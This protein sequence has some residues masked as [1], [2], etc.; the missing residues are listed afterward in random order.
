MGLLVSRLFLHARLLPASR[1]RH[2]K[3]VLGCSLAYLGLA[4]DLWSSLKNL[5]RQCGG[6]L[7][8]TSGVIELS[9]T[10]LQE[11]LLKDSSE[12]YI[13]YQQHTNA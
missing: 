11:Q 6:T 9:S 8:N 5:R 12:P 1:N 13:Q 2:A 3:C 10:Q 7:G 4:Y